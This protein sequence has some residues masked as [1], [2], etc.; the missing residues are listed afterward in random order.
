MNTLHLHLT[1]L[2]HN[3]KIIRDQIHDSTQCIGVI[4]AN[5][6]GGDAIYFAKRLELL[7]IDKLAVAYTEEGIQL[8]KQGIKTPIMVFYPQMDS[9]RT[10]I[11]ADLEPCLYSKKL[12]KSFKD[13]LDKMGIETRPI[14]SGNFANQPAAK[15]YKLCKKNEKFENYQK[16]QD[17][18]FLIGLHTRKFH[19]LNSSG[20][21]NYPEFQYDIVRCGI[22][23]LGFANTLEWDNL[24]KP[25]A[26]LKSK[27]SQLHQVEE[28]A[29]VGYDNG[30]IAPE[31]VTIATLPIGHADG[32]GRHFGHSRTSVS[33]HQQEAPIVGNI[34][35]DMLMVNVTGINCKE[36]DEVTFFGLNKSANSVAESGNT[37]SYELLAGIG[38]RV[39]RIVHS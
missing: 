11:A 25:V 9:L 14:I 38:P 33:I 17:M 16:V 13:H 8:R 21:F 1:H 37:I 15:L 39:K 36:G 31:A 10:L 26:V 34:C 5:A 30:W 6:Y 32:I 35:M 4:K 24:L 20:I 2:D 23:F 27:I 18:G 19:L 28:G 7:G 22:A 3:Y 12:L 29:S